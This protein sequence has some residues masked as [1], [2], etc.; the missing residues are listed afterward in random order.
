ML[1]RYRPILKGREGEML[2]IAHLSAD[3]VPTL[4]PIFEV[5]STGAGPTKDVDRFI[6]KTIN[7]IPL[8]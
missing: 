7:S 5:P 6:T 3:L 1:L 8:T 2:A 4:M